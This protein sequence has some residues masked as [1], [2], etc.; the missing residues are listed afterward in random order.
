MA[1]CFKCIHEDIC[2]ELKCGRPVDCVFFKDRSKFIELPCKVGDVVYFAKKKKFKYATI[3]QVNITEDNIY[4]VY[5][6][7]WVDFNRTRLSE[8]VEE[9]HFTIGDVYKTVFFTKE[10]AEQALKECETE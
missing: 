8:Y 9:G 4:F 3:V 2:E 5:V 1:N 10:E 7:K 6:G